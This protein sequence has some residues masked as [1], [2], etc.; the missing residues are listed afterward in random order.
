MKLSC[1]TVMLP[2]WTLDE[3]FDKL[4]EHHY[5]GV[6]LRCR[7]NPEKA[8]DAPL[9]RSF[10]GPHE[11]DIDPDN[12][13]RRSSE[14]RAAAVRTGLRVVALAPQCRLGEDDHLEKLLAGAVSIDPDAPPMIRVQALPYDRTQPYAPQFDAA[15]AGFARIAEAAGKRGVR[16]LYE[17]H[18]GT[19]AVT[20]SRALELLRDIDPATIGA[21]YDVPNMVVTGLEDTRM[22]IELLGP[23]LAHCHIGNRKPVSHADAS[24]ESTDWS[25]EFCGLTEGLAPIA[26]VVSDLSTIDYTDYLSLEDFGPGDDEEKIR[27]QG[28]CLRRLMDT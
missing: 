12:I 9:S 13:V 22:G 3:T 16:I 15:R 10:W 1:T 28:A 23:Y 20:A 18:A 26:Q 8:D 25:W 6:E 19:L 21:I 4:A 11:C 27:D 24:S 7:Y 5:D 17:I 2:R 14:I